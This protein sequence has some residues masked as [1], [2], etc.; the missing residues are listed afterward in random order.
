MMS[1]VFPGQYEKPNTMQNRLPR[2][3]EHIFKN[4]TAQNWH[5]ESVWDAE[6][7]EEDA[8]IPSSAD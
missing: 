3:P 6:G 1:N 2:K 5:T 8:S 7:V 4:G